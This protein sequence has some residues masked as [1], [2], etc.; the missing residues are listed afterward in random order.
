MTMKKKQSA[1]KPSARIDYLEQLLRLARELD[2]E[3]DGVR[4]PGSAAAILNGNREIIRLIDGLEE[5]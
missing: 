5:K 2:I 1:K 4:C 3:M